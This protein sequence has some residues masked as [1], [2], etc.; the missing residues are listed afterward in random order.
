MNREIG[1]KKEKITVAIVEDDGPV[2]RQLAA[3]VA[4]MPEC[5]CVGEYANGEN[6]VEGLRLRP[7]RVVLMDINLPGI[8]GVECV[9]QVSACLPGT[10]M[11][12]LTV[13]QD[14]DTIFE[15]LSV[16]A[17]GYLLK[18]V[19]KDDLIRAILDVVEGGS[20]MTGSIARKVVQSFQH[21]PAASAGLEMLTER[22]RE[23]LDLLAKGYVYK[24]I[25]VQLDISHWTVASFVQRIYQK[26]HVNSRAD[27]LA[28][29][30]S[31]SR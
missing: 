14:T 21:L 23:V 4:R 17:S 13:H 9:R 10:H 11:I 25:G 7:A 8:D 30:R 28:K 24:E 27:A 16:G 19:R 31:V 2:R 12:M 5:S 26:L 15:A 20:P 1:A 29:Y 3:I 6:A 22:E 18:P